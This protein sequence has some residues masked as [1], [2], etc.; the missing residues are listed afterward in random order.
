MTESDSPKPVV[1]AI[2]GSGTATGLHA[3]GDRSAVDSLASCMES[4][5]SQLRLGPPRSGQGGSFQL[6]F[7][8]Q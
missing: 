6:R 7:A 5:R 4:Q 8:A 1:A 3:T 2:D